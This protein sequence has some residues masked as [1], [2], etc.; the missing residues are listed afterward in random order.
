MN[1][2]AVHAPQKVAANTQYSCP[3]DKRQVPPSRPGG[4]RLRLHTFR[5]PRKCESVTSR[6]EASPTTYGFGRGVFGNIDIDDRVILVAGPF[7]V[8]LDDIS[9]IRVSYH[10]S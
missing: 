9:L 1:Q 6:R 2:R 10:R 4:S 3:K 8:I 5:F 7:C